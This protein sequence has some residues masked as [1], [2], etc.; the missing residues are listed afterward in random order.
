M[1]ISDTIIAQATP[2]GYSGVSIIRM[3]GPD[4]ITIVKKLTKTKKIQP[5]KATLKTIVSNGDDIV[6]SAIITCFPNQSL[7]QLLIWQLRLELE[8]QSRENILNVLS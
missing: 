2:L 6:D 7:K 3:S 5:R 4:S 1:N 8:W